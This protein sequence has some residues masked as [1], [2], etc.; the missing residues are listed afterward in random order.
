M[1]TRDPEERSRDYAWL[2]FT[3]EFELEIHLYSPWRLSSNRMAEERR[4]DYSNVSNVVYMIQH[5][6]RI[7]RH[8]NRLGMFA[9]LTECEVV[10]YIKIQIDQT[11]TMH[12]VARDVQGA[13]VDN[14]VTVVVGS[15]NDV[16]RQA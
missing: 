10:R 13:V 2:R 1:C 14:S 8:R 9:R 11:R 3:S 16:D 12:R 7:Q 6:K 5:V 4:G 15:R